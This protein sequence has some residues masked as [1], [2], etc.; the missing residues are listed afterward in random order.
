MNETEESSSEGISITRQLLRESAVAFEQLAL[1]FRR[2]DDAIPVFRREER[3]ALRE[4][5]EGLVRRTCDLVCVCNFGTR[6]NQPTKGNTM[7]SRFSKIFHAIGALA[8]AVVVAG[9]QGV[10]GIPS[11]VVA[12]AGIVAYFAGALGKALLGD[13]PEAK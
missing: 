6:L 12:G 2:A 13:K 8:T 11:K 9:S 7:F 10:M 4:E 5:L 3:R 1:R